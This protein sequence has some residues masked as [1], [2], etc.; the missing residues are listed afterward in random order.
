MVGKHQTT[1]TAS[2]D[3]FMTVAAQVT[4]EIT[5]T[6]PCEMTKLISYSVADMTY[7]MTVQE[8]PPTV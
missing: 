4:F 2:F 7:Q 5:L 6:H 8:S 1:I 3:S